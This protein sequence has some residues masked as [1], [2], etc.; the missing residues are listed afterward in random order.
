M[1]KSIVVGSTKVDFLEMIFFESGTGGIEGEIV[2]AQGV[3]SSPDGEE[4]PCGSNTELAGR[5]VKVQIED[6]ERI[7]AWK[8]GE[9]AGQVDLS[10]LRYP[11]G[12]DA[13]LK[14]DELV[15]LYF[16]DFY[17]LGSEKIDRLKIS[18]L[19]TN[20]DGIKGKIVEAHGTCLTPDG[21]EFTCF[22]SSQAGGK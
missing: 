6:I 13:T 4:L 19:E 20:V 11:Q 1:N 16:N 12:P 9:N 21:S 15:T 18:V 17:P 7:D 2:S 3:C 22:L 10:I 14:T 8:P 5:V